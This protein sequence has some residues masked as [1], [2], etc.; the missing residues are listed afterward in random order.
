MNP[1][2]TTA[3]AK[4]VAVLMVLISVVLHTLFF[5]VLWL[6]WSFNSHLPVP[7]RRLYLFSGAYCNKL[8]VFVVLSD[9]E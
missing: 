5:L 9:I 6:F 2:Q 8:S 7:T 4:F 3:Q 1:D